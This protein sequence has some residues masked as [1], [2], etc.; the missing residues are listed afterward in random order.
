LFFT[1]ALKLESTWLI[2][3]LFVASLVSL[4]LSLAYFL[5]ELNHALIAFHLDIRVEG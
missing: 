3:G 5:R 1:A 4:I 2:G